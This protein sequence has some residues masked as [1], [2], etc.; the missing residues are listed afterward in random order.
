MDLTA[1]SQINPITTDLEAVALIATN[2]VV[3]EAT[4]VTSLLQEVV[5]GEMVLEEDD[6]SIF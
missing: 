3:Q 5:L 2:P 1:I 6:K 4:T